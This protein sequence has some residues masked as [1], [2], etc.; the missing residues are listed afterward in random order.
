V[1]PNHHLAEAVFLLNWL[2]AAWQLS[3]WLAGWLVGWLAGWLAGSHPLET[4]HRT[5]VFID[6]PPGWAPAILAEGAMT[7]PVT[8]SGG[9]LFAS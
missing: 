4:L 5:G 9:V 7:L 6:A 1:V 3:S 2:A 8:L